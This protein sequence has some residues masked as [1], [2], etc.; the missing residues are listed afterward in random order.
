MPSILKHIDQI[1]REKGRDAVFASFET[2]Q[3]Q[4]DEPFNYPAPNHTN[5]NWLSDFNRLNLIAWLNERGIA[6]QDAGEY[7]SENGWRSY[8]GNLFIDVPF[9]PDDAQY[10]QVIEHLENADGTPRDP[11]L[12]L[13]VC[14]L[15]VAMKNAH[16]DEPGFWEKWA[17]TF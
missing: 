14:T 9:D 7:A 1:A 8:N 16:H 3:D 4:S 10:Q 15:E 17:E 6:H 5:H 2:G 11:Q 13:W 12:K